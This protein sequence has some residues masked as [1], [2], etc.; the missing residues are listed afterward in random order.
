[1]PVAIALYWTLG[2]ASESAVLVRQEVVVSLVFC[3]GIRLTHN[4]SRRWR[5]LGHEDWR[6]TALRARSGRW[7]WLVELFGIDVMPTAVVFLGCLSLYP[8][9]SAGTRGFGAIDWVA[10]AVV[11]AAIAI[12]ATADQQLE[13]FVR[14]RRHSG[15]TLATGLWAVSRHPNYFGEVL[16]WWGLYLFALAADPSYWWVVAGPL[17]VTVLFVFVSVPMMDGRSLER[18]PGYEEHM[19]RVSGLVP[20][21]PRR[22]QRVTSEGPTGGASSS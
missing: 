22:G 21:F 7:F 19:R 18:R 8:S 1:A 20:W 16:F 17:A 13:R 5:G 2:T 9:L 4:W 14:T 3:W 11:A 15:Q 6:Y 10:T 12:E